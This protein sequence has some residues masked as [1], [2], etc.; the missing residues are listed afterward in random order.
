MYIQIVLL[1]VIIVFWRAL[2][3]WALKWWN[4]MIF[5]IHIIHYIVLS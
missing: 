4:R 1:D 2:D 3:H 5:T